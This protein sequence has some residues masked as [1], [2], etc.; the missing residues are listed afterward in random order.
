VFPRHP[1]YHEAHI[2]MNIIYSDAF[3]DMADLFAVTD[4][5]TSTTFVA[6]PVMIIKNKICEDSSIP[7]AIDTTDLTAIAPLWARCSFSITTGNRYS[8]RRLTAAT[9]NEAMQYVIAY[10]M[11]HKLKITISIQE[12]HFRPGLS[13]LQ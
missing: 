2:D 1:L 11:T 7:N 13:Y 8:N 9:L 5:P 4:P 12:L 10:G 6:N 3:M